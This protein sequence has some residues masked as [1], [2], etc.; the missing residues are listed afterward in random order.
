M[1]WSRPLVAICTA[2]LLFVA[3][4]IAL[5][6]PAHEKPQAATGRAAERRSTKAVAEDRMDIS[7]P[8]VTQTRSGET[9]LLRFEAGLFSRGVLMTPAAR[10]SL[11][12]IGLQIEPR[13]QRLTLTIVGH[14]DDL[15]LILQRRFPD[16][17]ALAIARA[18]TVIRY[19]SS[20]TSIPASVWTIRLAEND[21]CFYPCDSDAGRL[22]NRTV[23]ILLGSP[24][25]T[26]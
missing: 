15:P 5:K 13:W 3:I 24:Q 1:R 19:L 9:T 12:A 2:L 20:V 11:K 22:R 17:E 8:G 14:T 21:A 18:D 16:N 4:G 26:K 6:R 7:A 10:R 23:D 25:E